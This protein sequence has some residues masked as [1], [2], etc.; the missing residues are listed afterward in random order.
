[1]KSF[2]GGLFGCFG[3]GVALVVAI[4][5]I[6]IISG[7]GSHSTTSGSFQAATSASPVATAKATAKATVAPVAAKVLFDKTGSGIGKTAIFTTPSE[8]EIDYYFDCTGFGQTG[9]FSITVYDGA[10]QMKDLPANAL[11]LKG[12]DVAYEHNLSGPYYL[13]VNSEC[14]W[15]VTVKG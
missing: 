4:A 6:A 2:K 8:W 7:G 15:H 13:E 14:D 1:M 11:G 3:V 12:S 5:I 9:N 10:S